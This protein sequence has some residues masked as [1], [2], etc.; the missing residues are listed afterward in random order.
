MRVDVPVSIGEFLDK[1]SILEIKAERIADARKRA[2]VEA[3]LALLRERRHVL[4][5]VLAR[6]AIA[7]LLDEL[8]VINRRLWDVED[9]LRV[10][11]RESDF[12]AEFVALARSVYTE[13]DRRAAVKRRL[14]ELTGSELVE[15]KSH[16]VPTS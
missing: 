2:N 11:E 5:L 9:R 3:E 1:I 16:P 4:A 10:L 8:G 12:G 15:E 13:N 6:A 14:N 7:P